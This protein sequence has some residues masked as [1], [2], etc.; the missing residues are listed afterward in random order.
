M[1]SILNSSSKCNSYVQ[2]LL[3]S[4]EHFQ[5]RTC[6][7]QF[8]S[9]KK[10]QKK[11]ENVAIELIIITYILNYRSECKNMRVYKEGENKKDPKRSKIYT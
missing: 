6:N 8:K 10:Y 9:L 2:F 11:S 5:R 1:K 3:I 4:F 7:N